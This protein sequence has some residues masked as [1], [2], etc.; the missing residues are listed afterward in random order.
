M[1]EEEQETQYKAI[2]SEEQVKEQMES[3]TKSLEL[4]LAL[5]GISKTKA[6]S[7]V[8]EKEKHVSKEIIKP[9]SSKA[10]TPCRRSKPANAS[11]SKVVGRENNS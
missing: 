2:S 11:K 5:Q 7:Q 10:E 8:P 1:V 9:S 4:M 3:I 6:L